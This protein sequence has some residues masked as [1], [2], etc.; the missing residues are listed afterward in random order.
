[1]NNKAIWLTKHWG[2]GIGILMTIS[3]I[4]MAS[5]GYMQSWVI[6]QGSNKLPILEVKYDEIITT[7]FNEDVPRGYKPIKFIPD[8]HELKGLGT[9]MMILGTS[10]LFGCANALKTEYERLETANWIIRQSEFK[11][12]DLEYTQGVEVDRFAIE[13]DAQQEISNMQQPPK[14]YYDIEDEQPKPEPEFS[15]T[16]TGFLAWLTKKAEERNSNIFE[17]K[18]CRVQSWAGQKYSTEQIISWV[19]E[20]VNV[21]QVEWVD[22]EKKSFRLLND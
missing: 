18:W 14:K 17:I 6:S 3:G 8:N 21:E 15:R 16:A 19:E 22:T 5:P 12:A 10:L 11:L 7:R 2:L 13:Y 1:M 9:S 20:L 4:V